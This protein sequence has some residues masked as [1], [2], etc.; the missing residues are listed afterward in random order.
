MAW[1]SAFP[2]LILTSRLTGSQFSNLLLIAASFTEGGPE[3]LLFHFNSL[4]T[5]AAEDPAAALTFANVQRIWSADL[6]VS[7]PDRCVFRPTHAASPRK[8]ALLTEI[9]ITADDSF[10]LYVNGREVG[11][12]TDY[13][14]TTR[15]CV[16]LRPCANVFAVDAG[17]I[18]SAQ[19]PA[20][21][22]AP[23][24]ITYSDGTR[25]TVGADPS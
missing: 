7:P 2:V 9:S 8:T 16:A 10:V 19:N 1:Y 13:R 11:T 5:F 15:L 24:E 14:T 12:S 22:R 23:I 6:A 17:N 3:P 4:F 18:G 25:E 20:G 21:L